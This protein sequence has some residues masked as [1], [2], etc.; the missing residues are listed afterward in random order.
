VARG[1][2]EPRVVHD[3]RNRLGEGP[4]WDPASGG[5]L[6]VDILG[7]TVHR[8]D[9]SGHGIRLRCTGEVSAAI[10]RARGGLVLA[11]GHDLVLRDA[12]GDSRVVATVETEIPA[13]RFNDCRCDPAGRVWAGTMSKT[14]TAG[15]GSLYRLTSGLELTQVLTGTTISNGIAWSPTGDQMYFVDSTTQRIDLFEFDL[16]RGELGTRRTFVE[17]PQADGLPDGLAVDVEG[18]VWVALFGGACVRRYG[19]QGRLDCE[20]KLPVTNPTC[21][22]F[23]GEDLSTMYITSAQH[24]LTDAQLRAEPLAGCLFELRP[25][26]A[27][28]PGTPFAG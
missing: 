17:I 22:A 4:T 24:R 1:P 8:W 3:E 6:W 19:V 2:F 12:D 23:G 20:I 25:G 9:A 5:L 10:P 26:V 21:P 7:G 14:R 11:V 28:L 27:G 18:G 16:D 15:D 13:N